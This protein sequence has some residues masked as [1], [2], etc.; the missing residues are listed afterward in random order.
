[1]DELAETIGGLSTNA[2]EWKPSSQRGNAPSYHQNSPTSP[3]PISS[4]LQVSPPGRSVSTGSDPRGWQPG[5]EWKPAS[6]KEFVPSWKQAQ[7][8]EPSTGEY[9]GEPQDETTQQ[10]ETSIPAGPV[11]PLPVRTMR[12]LGVSDELWRHER[13][14]AL[15]AMREMDPTDPR[16]KAIPPPFSNAYQL[17]SVNNMGGTRSSFGYPAATFKC[18]NQEDGNLYCLRRFDNVRSVS[19]KIAAAVTDRWN[20]RATLK[21]GLSPVEHPGVVRFYRCFV[22]NRAVFFLH[23]YVPGAR[24]LRERFNNTHA[25]M[26]EPL[27]WSCVVQ[28]VSAIRAIHAGNL[29]CRVLDLNH[30]LCTS[31]DGSMDRIR[32]QVNCLGVVD[33][34]EFEA[35]KQVGELQLEDMRD[36]GRL[37]LSLAWYSE[38]TRNCDK[39][40]MSQCNTF[41]SQNYS[42]ELH[43]LALSLL[44]PNVN[45][46]SIHDVCRAISGRVFDEMDLSR[47]TADRTQAALSAE[48]ESGRALR[49]LLK[50]GFVN[51]RPEF[52]M[53][54]R[55]TE[56]GD[57]YA[58]KLFRDYVFHQAD[59]SGRPVMDL[60]HV[61]TSLNKLD[62]ADEE[63]IVLTS[64]DGKSM[65]VVSYAEVARCLDNAFNECCGGNVMGAMHY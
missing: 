45:V 40:T 52:G 41:V 32:V 65:F 10:I 50:L 26:P 17:D 25:T 4:V 55:W 62:A 42:R 16:H 46:P 39:D 24:T 20:Q 49:L 27:L 34:L 33:A 11:P 64:R 36:L 56:S 35:R 2:K 14:L 43:N 9:M 3:R 1:M 13:D 29:A 5:T 48:Y 44:T 59:G 47:V 18:V 23:Q 19:Y 12:S 51:E 28:L 30:I 54:R 38:I 57:C 37:I 22:S 15:E 6:P 58:L 7:I 21:S 8:V 63:K 61:I 53:N 31:V 60:G